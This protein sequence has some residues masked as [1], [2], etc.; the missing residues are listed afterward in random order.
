MGIKDWLRSF[1]GREET[2]IDATMPLEV[3]GG[4]LDESIRRF[5]LDACINMIANIIA[6]TEF[7]TYE[8]G[9]E[10]K[11]KAYY[12]YNI[13]PNKRE[14]G[15]D[16]WRAVVYRML[17]D[18]YAAV[19]IRDGQLYLT[20]SAT[21]DAPDPFG[22]RRFNISIGSKNIPAREQEVLYF[23][24]N[25]SRVTA[26]LNGVYKTYGDLI[27]FSKKN[28]K[29]RNAKRGIL[30][31]D[32]PA[33]M[34]KEEREVRDQLFNVHFKNFFQAERGA[35]LPLTKGYT[36]KGED[37]GTKGSRPS[38]TR[39]ITALIYDYLDI[40][41]I[42]LNI[43]PILIR[44]HIADSS[45]AVNN[46]IS[47]CVNPIVRVI[48]AES[49]RKMYAEA[50]YLHRSYVR[51]DTTKIKVTDITDLAETVDILF[52]TGTHTV[53]D[54]LELLGRERVSDPACDI[55]YISKNYITSD[56]AQQ[57]VKGGEKD[58]GQ[59]N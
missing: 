17:Y 14:S 28:Y 38:D 27:D 32:A 48:E 49:N 42:A 51:I 12:I 58:D 33:S 3:G 16:F 15:A 19:L 59:K 50:D 57:A 46:L 6:S 24:H 8:N 22:P 52:R 10:V 36:Y 45:M 39:D 23:Q 20:D 44:G 4:G 56:E 55:R 47:F 41:A 25:N 2:T 18:G 5:A 11:E 34:T 26:I 21:I 35:V 53:N 13:A 9:N 43:P 31:I 30:N 1:T 40:V 54:N 29:V 7:R 37:E